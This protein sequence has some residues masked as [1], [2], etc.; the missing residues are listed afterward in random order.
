M[1]AALEQDEEV[2]KHLISLH[3]VGRLGEAEE[4]RTRYLVEFRE[5]FACP[6]CL[7]YRGGYLTK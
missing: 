1:I 2:E 7:V 6:R 4:V 3:P 5:S